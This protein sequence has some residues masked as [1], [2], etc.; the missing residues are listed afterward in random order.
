MPVGGY[1]LYYTISNGLLNWWNVLGGMIYLALFI[2]V[3]MLKI[4][5]G[6]LQKPDSKYPFPKKEFE[7]GGYAEKIRRLKKK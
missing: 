6:I 2:R 5:Y 4:G 7:R 1:W 3:F